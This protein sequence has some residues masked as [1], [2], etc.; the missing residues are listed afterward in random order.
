MGD[1]NDWGVWSK[2]VL[3]ELERLN[4]CYL[5]LNNKYL[6][7]INKSSNNKNEIT[8]LKVKAGIWGG[9]GTAIVVLMGLGVAIL[10][11]LEQ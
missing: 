8:S 11:R 2:Y 7:I 3:K 1:D 10:K 5:E 6:E 9:L 4:S